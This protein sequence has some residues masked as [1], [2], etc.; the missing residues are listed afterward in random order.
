MPPVND[1]ELRSLLRALSAAPRMASAAVVRPAPATP[2]EP[3][4]LSPDAR[5]RKLKSV[6]GAALARRLHTDPGSFDRID[7]AIRLKPREVDWIRAQM[8]DGFTLSR[9]VLIALAL[10]CDV[11]VRVHEPNGKQP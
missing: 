4:Y 11:S 8:L 2:L 5:L 1:Q 3:V 7:R 6:V 9:L 10:G